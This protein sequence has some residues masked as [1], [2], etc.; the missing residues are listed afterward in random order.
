MYVHVHTCMS[1]LMYMCMLFDVLCL[2]FL[3]TSLLR[4]QFYV[5]AVQVSFHTYTS[6]CMLS[7]F[8]FTC[9]VHVK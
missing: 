7:F 9:S 5:Q 2:F 6:T 1:N 3:C 8:T 4:T